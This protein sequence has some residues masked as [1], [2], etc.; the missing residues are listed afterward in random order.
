M[1]ERTERYSSVAIAFHWVIAA[2][3]IFNITVG[4]LHDPVPAF[5]MLMPAHKAVG[6]T[7]LV[8]TALRV[9]WRLAHRPPVLP[10]GMA[11]WERATAHAVHWGLY[12]LM[13]VMPIT[14][15]MLVSGK[16]KG[17][18]SWFG[19]FDVPYLPVSRAA[20]AAG[21][22]AHGILGWV[23]LALVLLHVAAALRHHFIL[24]DRVLARMA[25]IMDRPEIERN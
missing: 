24:R 20:S 22:Q 25:P 4:I 14:G 1:I 16:P 13:I 10:A 21:H 23:M 18:L 11:H 8:L 3:V 19:L 15:W 5:R 7:V 12:A 17:P 2:L 9:A 6:L